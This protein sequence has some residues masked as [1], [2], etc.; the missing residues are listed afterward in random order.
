MDPAQPSRQTR[1]WSADTVDLYRAHYH[2]L[3]R[4]ADHRLNDHGLAEQVVQDAFTRFGRGVS[5]EPGK[6]LAYLRSMVRNASIEVI[7]TA[8]RHRSKHHLLADHPTNGSSDVSG[9]VADV[10]A[11]S[12]ALDSL[13]PQQRRVLSARYLLDL[14]VKETAAALDMSVGTVKTHTHRALNR[15][16]AE[17]QPEL[18]AA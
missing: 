5:V 15:L 12:E 10:G 6:E 18:L 9:R 3:V 13:S 4:L 7:R 2:S 1:T 11:V 17:A 16:R 14:S 8:I